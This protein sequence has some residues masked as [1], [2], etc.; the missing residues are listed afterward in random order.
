MFNDVLR[1]AAKSDL[2]ADI[3]GMRGKHVTALL[4]FPE[5]L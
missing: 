2:I 4:T 1:D 3:V 5:R